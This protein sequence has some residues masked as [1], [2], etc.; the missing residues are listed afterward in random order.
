[1]NRPDITLGFVTPWYGPNLPGGAETLT[2]VTAAR[3]AAA[4]YRV[5]ILTTCIEKFQAD[6]GH[7]HY[8][9]G[10]TTVDGMPVRRFPVGARDRAA[11][12][13]LNW[14][15]MH[16]LT[17]EPA[18]EATFIGEMIRAPALVDY[19]DTH[20]DDYLYFFIPYMFTPTYLGVRAAPQRA[21]VIPCLHDE[22][23]ARLNLYR[24]ALPLARALV[25]NAPVERDLAARLLPAADQARVVIG[26]GIDAPVAVDPDRFRARYGI[27]RPFMLYVGRRET[28]KNTPLL[29]EY[30]AR[31]AA[32]HDDPWVLALA[33]PGELRVPPGLG[34]RVVD[35]GFI[36]T[37]DKHDAY[38][39]A[40][41]FVN[42]SVN[43]SFSI[44]LLESWHAGTPALVHGDCAVTRDHVQ[45]ANG[46][47]YFRGYDE[48]AAALRYLRAHPAVAA[49]LGA[50]GRRYVD[51]HFQWP[52]IIAH[53][54]RL[55]AGLLAEERSHERRT[56]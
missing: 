38:A 45:Q 41:L 53:Y 34:E 20:A 8:R 47:L 33:G 55:I 37:A 56:V 10:L 25:F 26:M 48:F 27:D 30:W 31:Y 16:G 35:L 40:D 32:E 52:T 4:G 22:A 44:V 54:D 23:Y 5:E 42:P 51:R 17:I 46:G 13:A 3:L 19:V 39:A 50:Q 24:E 21:V 1:M 12:D 6:W 29:L 7:N 14:R 11:F 43:E 15:L 36:P 28:G 9:P 18:E 49:A 2:R